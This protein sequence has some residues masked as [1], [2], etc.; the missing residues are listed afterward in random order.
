MCCAGRR[1][2][3]SADI[4]RTRPTE[5]PDA[6]P[7]RRWRC[8]LRAACARACA[9]ASARACVCVHSCACVCVRA[10][11]VCACACVCVRACACVCVRVL[12]GGVGVTG[13]PRG[14]AHHGLRRA[15]LDPPRWERA[16]RQAPHVAARRQPAARSALPHSIGP[17]ALMRA[18]GGR[19][20]PAAAGRFVPSDKRCV[21][22]GACRVPCRALHAAPVAACAACVSHDGAEREGC[23]HLRRLVGVGRRPGTRTMPVRPW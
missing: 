5:S 13:A 6:N 16:G 3:A 10:W 22:R 15:T 14:C 8:S 23:A 21:A 9:G 7:H 20:L 18:C 19:R 17:R 12:Y 4:E 1:R 2:S 11:S